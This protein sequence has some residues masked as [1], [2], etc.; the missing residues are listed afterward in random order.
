MLITNV[1]LAH[2]VNLL[3]QEELDAL[4]KP[5][6]VT[7]EIKSEEINSTAM[8]AQL[9][10]HSKFQTHQEIYVLPDHSLTVDVP[11]EEITLDTH[12]LNAEL[13]KSKI[14]ITPTNALTLVSVINSHTDSQ[15][16]TPHVV[17]ANDVTG[18]HK[19]QT[20]SLKIDVS[21]DQDHNVTAFKDMEMEDTH[22][23]TAH[24][25]KLE[26][27]LITK[28]VLMH[29]LAQQLTQSNLLLIEL[30]VVDARLV[31]SQDSSQMLQE[32]AALPDH[33]PSVLIALLDNQMMDT[34]VK[35]A[36]QVKLSAQLTPRH[37]TLQHVLETNK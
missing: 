30:L 32:L 36:H 15:E 10:Q 13:D 2:L 33:L 29:H 20:Q 25:D 21:L 28:Y 35:T 23:L 1:K 26:A 6:P 14:Q 8:H 22:V 27:E 34:P 7:K 37:A 9:A 31:N 3:M 19:F 5:T 11:A 24:S 16:I 18:H 4:V 17:D 12:A